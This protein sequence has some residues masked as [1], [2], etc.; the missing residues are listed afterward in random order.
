M[1]NRLLTAGLPGE[2]GKRGVLS[3]G[4]IKI[5]GLILMVMD[6]LCQMFASQGAPLWL[7]W[8]GRPVAAMFLFLCAEGFI[9]TRNKKLYMLRFLAAAVLMS[10]GNQLL[11]RLFPVEEVAL[12]NNIFGALFL[13]VFYMLMADLLAAGVREKRAGRILL[14]LGGILLPLIV[15]FALT[16]LLFRTESPG[17]LAQILFFAIPTP[18]AVEGGILMVVIGVLFYLLRRWRWAQA[19]VPVAAGLLVALGSGYGDGI[20]DAQWLMV[21]A[22]LPI[23]LY[24]GRRGWGAKYFFYAFY[25]LHIY[26]LYLVAWVLAR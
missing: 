8:F 1:G 25:P 5:I 10:L 22:A 4:A 12:I 23:L 26:L 20:P 9:H 6:H 3:G 18:F 16:G 24:N 13:C 17:L 19:L 21:F 2:S 15:G 11:G 14:A 7:K